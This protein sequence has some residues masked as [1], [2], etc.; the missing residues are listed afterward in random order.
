MV[1]SLQARH[2]GW[3][4]LGIMGKSMAAN[5][6]KA[7]AR[8]SVWNRTPS[9]CDALADLGAAVADSPADLA[10]RQPQILCINVSDTPDVEQ[11]LFG[12]EGVVHGAH[13]GLIVIDHSTI[14]PQATRD[15]AA[16]LAEQG[17]TLLD[18]PVSGGD[19][20]AKAGTLS[21][22]VGGDAEAFAAAQPVL[23]CMGKTI[24]HLG[25]PGS[26]Q[27]CKAC[28]QAAVANTLMGVCEALRLAGAGGLDVAQ[29]IE[30]LG[31]G[32]AGSWQLAQLGPR[33]VAG[34]YA[35]GFMIDLVIKDL[36]IVLDC[37]AELK[38]DPAGVRA[39]LGYFEKV[40]DSRPEG[41]R[42]GTQAMALA[43]RE[44]AC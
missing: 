42:L 4:G 27:L 44:D 23:A 33:I 13:K 26:G 15:F 30:V 24:T 18:A 32:A 11:V 25:G 3:I 17:I 36:R 43:V 31:G 1:N 35:P 37:A 9:R 39:A 21:I 20:G 10:A 40:R 6:L 5:L 14:L 16:R 19:Q 22:M 7:Q 28:N 2:I 38:M 12:P 34:D 8:L 29:V 41:G